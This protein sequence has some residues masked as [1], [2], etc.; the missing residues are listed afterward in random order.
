MNF[1]LEQRLNCMIVCIYSIYSATIGRLKQFSL[2]CIKRRRKF[3]MNWAAA[4]TC[5]RPTCG[6]LLLH[7]SNRSRRV[8]AVFSGRRRRRREEEARLRLAGRGGVIAGRRYCAGMQQRRPCR[9]R[10][11]VWV[12]FCHRCNAGS[13]WRIAS[14]PRAAA[15]VPRGDVCF[16]RHQRTAYL[17]MAFASR[18]H[19]GSHL[20]EKQIN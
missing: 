13:E 12:Q 11:R 1:C 16:R 2:Y 18:E 7:V 6:A 9:S 10:W 4:A 5:S 3:L 17:R 14:A 20:T 15:P 8:G 19:Q